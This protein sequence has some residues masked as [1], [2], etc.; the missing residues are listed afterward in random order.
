MDELIEE[1]RGLTAALASSL[2]DKSQS[3]CPGQYKV[4]VPPLLIPSLKMRPYQREGLDWLVTLN[5]HDTN[6]I[7]ADEMGLGKTL[8]SI[9]LLAHLASRTDGRWTFG[10]HLIVVP[11]SV[12]YN[13]KFEFNR[14]APGF[15]VRTVHMG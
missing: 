7:L 12:V 8:Q 1:L 2:L 3:R 15:K 14:W 9:A 5:D 11:T 4:P 10:P 6:C 13:W